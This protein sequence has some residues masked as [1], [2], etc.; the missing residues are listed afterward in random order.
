MDYSWDIMTNQNVQM[1]ILRNATQKI[2]PIM[3]SSANWLR[4]W[5]AT[6]WGIMAEEGQHFWQD[7]Q[8]NPIMMAFLL[9][10]LLF[11]STMLILLINHNFFGTANP[12]PQPERHHYAIQKD[13]RVTRS[14]THAAR[15]N[16]GRLL[17]ARTP[18]VR[19]RHQ[20]IFQPMEPAYN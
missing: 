12:E 4:G 8:K 1:W 7:L 13:R 10:Y 11:S 15:Y 9:A 19:R 18:A 2:M 5:M 17:M 14:M 16:E 3:A 6:Y 20:M